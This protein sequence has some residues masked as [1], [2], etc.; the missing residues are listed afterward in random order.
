M[1]NT[2]VIPSFIARAARKE[3]IEIHGTGDQFRQFTHASDIAKAF[4][5]AI[6]AN[7]PS[8]V[9]NVVSPERVTIIQ[10]ATAIA[11]RFGVRLEFRKPRP[12]D[13][14]SVAVS[15]R[16]IEQELGWK[17]E[18]QFKDGLDALIGGLERN[19]SAPS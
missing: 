15:S 2:A 17:A 14:P 10:L 4:Y 12:H 16:L 7:N 8:R 13:A 11:S 1:R 18:V 5:L 6:V 3:P 9:Y 19:L